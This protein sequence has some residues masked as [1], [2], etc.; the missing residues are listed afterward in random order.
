MFLKMTRL[1]FADIAACKA[2]TTTHAIHYF[3][4]M[5]E[6]YYS[7]LCHKSIEN[8]LYY[9]NNSYQPKQICFDTSVLINSI[10][11]IY[12]LHTSICL[13]INLVL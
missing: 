13:N 6:Q 5:N 9:T 2:T 1:N 8:E 12:N 4:Q 7:F 11:D 10:I 3:H